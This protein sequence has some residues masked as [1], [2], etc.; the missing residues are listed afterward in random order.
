MATEL[1]VTAVIYHHGGGS[2]TIIQ[3]SLISPEPLG[4]PNPYA[5]TFK[6]YSVSKNFNVFSLVNDNATN[7][8]SFVALDASNKIYLF[9][10][11]TTNDMLTSLKISESVSALSP[12]S[13]SGTLARAAFAEQFD[14]YLFGTAS[15]LSFSG[16]A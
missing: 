9:I 4:S 1:K 12:Y 13:V 2:N 7:F 14:Y 3:S 6:S 5:V 10:L 15:S 16:Q 11:D 8:P